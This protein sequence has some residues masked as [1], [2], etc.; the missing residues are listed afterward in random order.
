MPD[1]TKVEWLLPG[2]PLYFGTKIQ[3]LFKDF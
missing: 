1:D 3:G 2:F